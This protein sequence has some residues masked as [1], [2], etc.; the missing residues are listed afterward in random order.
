M[1]LCRIFSLE[2][3]DCATT[4]RYTWARKKTNGNEVARILYEQ[5]FSHIKKMFKH[6]LH[7]CKVVF[8][9]LHRASSAFPYPSA[10]AVVCGT[11]G[12]SVGAAETS[13]C[14][15]WPPWWASTA[16]LAMG[17]LWLFSLPPSLLDSSAMSTMGSTCGFLPFLLQLLLYPAPR[18]RS[19]FIA[20]CG[21][22]SPV[23]DG[24]GIIP[25]SFV[26][27]GVGGGISSAWDICR[28]DR[29]SSLRAEVEGDFRDVLTC[30]W[31]WVTVKQEKSL[32]NIVCGGVKGQRYSSVPKLEDMESVMLNTASSIFCFMLLF[33]LPRSAC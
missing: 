13:A 29:A 5:K 24:M 8:R 30:V 20:C 22:C 17:K 31:S 23:V 1:W 14:S 32:G 18:L 27:L 28:T 4:V 15:A 10:T 6:H 2:G 21:A 26:L 16:P 25:N 19:V 12:P 9:G 7:L 11:S 3:S 33:S